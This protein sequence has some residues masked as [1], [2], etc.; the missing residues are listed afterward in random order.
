MCCSAVH[1]KS[2]KYKCSNCCGVFG[3]VI[4]VLSPIALV[5]ALVAVIPVGFWS[6]T[7]FEKPK[8]SWAIGFIQLYMGPPG[9]SDSGWMCYD[10]SSDGSGST[11][12]VDSNIISTNS[13]NS[14]TCTTNGDCD[15]GLWFCQSD[16]ICGDNPCNANSTN[17]CQKRELSNGECESGC[18]CAATNWDGGDCSGRPSGATCST[19]SHCDSDVCQGNVCCSTKGK[20]TGCTACDSSNN[21]DCLTCSTGYSLS[22]RQCIDNDPCGLGNCPESWLNDAVCD[23]NCKCAATNWDGGDCSGRPSGA[24]CSTNS[25]CDS[26][27]CQGNVCCST[28][29]KSTGCTACDSSNNGDCLTCSTGYRLSNRQCIDDYPCVSGGYCPESYL[30]DNYCDSSCNCAVTNYDEGDC[31]GRRRLKGQGFNKTKSMVTKDLPQLLYHK[32]KELVA[33]MVKPRMSFK[34]TSSKKKENDIV[35]TIHPALKNIEGKRLRHHLKTKIFMQYLSRSG[36]KAHPQRQLFLATLADKIV[37]MEE[38]YNWM[39]TSAIQCIVSFV[40]GA[41][42]HIPNDGT[43]VHVEME[44]QQAIPTNL[45]AVVPVSQARMSQERTPTN[46]V[47]RAPVSQAPLPTTVVAVAPV[48]QAPMPT[49]I[50]AIPPVSQTEFKFCTNCGTKLTSDAKFCNACGHR[51]L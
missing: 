50:V 41:S 12:D 30:N 5:L 39:K 33:H 15:D 18:N 11:S 1:N 2:P 48:S 6:C 9:C 23:S 20:S 42:A 31:T 14:F 43:K 27:V 22:N 32:F 10:Y 35:K 25:H 28:K 4:E 26:D 40:A 34:N 7:H 37:E 45:V 3:I 47:A 46:S 21:G 13:D 51:E 36:H 38:D 44:M 16:G 24:T 8:D 17:H 49:N 29:G 19:N